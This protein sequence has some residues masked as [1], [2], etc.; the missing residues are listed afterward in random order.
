MSGKV[1]ST[2]VNIV[3]VLLDIYRIRLIEV[4]DSDPDSM[5]AGA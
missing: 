1:P 3:S 2:F 4:T 5:C